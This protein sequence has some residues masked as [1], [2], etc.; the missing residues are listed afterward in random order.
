[1]YCVT[2]SVPNN[3]NQTDASFLSHLN[4]ALTFPSSRQPE[5]I[6]NEWNTS[7]YDGT[8]HILMQQSHYNAAQHIIM[9]HVTL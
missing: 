2:H 9:E 8:H 7:H 1:M 5:G 3:S 6:G 4:C